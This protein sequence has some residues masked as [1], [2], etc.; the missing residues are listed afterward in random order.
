M[1]IET[2]NPPQ[3]SQPVGPYSQAVLVLGE[4]RWLHIAGQIGAD[5]DGVLAGSFEEQA[6]Q[7][8]KNI[9]ALLQAAGMDASHLVKVVTYLT[10]E[11]DIPLLGP[12]RLAYLGEAR[13][14]ATLIVAKAL[15]RKEWLIE[16]EAV[17]YLE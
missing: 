9:S 3:V 6:E 7:A 1:P 5:A 2:M 16:I 10:R 13:P 4:G 12:I 8:W 15:A 17:A 11:E 14:A